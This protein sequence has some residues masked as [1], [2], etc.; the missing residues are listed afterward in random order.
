MGAFS[1][2]PAPFG[3]PWGGPPWGAWEAE[4]EEDP[5][6]KKLLAREAGG[7]LGEASAVGREEDLSPGAGLEADAE[8]EDFPG[9]A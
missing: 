8:P 3:T 7:A 4:E 6:L 9:V 1:S 5:I 2:C